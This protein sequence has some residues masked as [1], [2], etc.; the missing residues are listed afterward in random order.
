MLLLVMQLVGL[1]ICWAFNSE[2]RPIPV[3][4]LCVMAIGAWNLELLRMLELGVWSFTALQRY[5]RTKRPLPFES[6]LAVPSFLI[7]PF[8]FTAPASSS[9]AACAAAS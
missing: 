5:A 6:F 4:H 2:R 3:G 7:C 1:R 8:R 9:R